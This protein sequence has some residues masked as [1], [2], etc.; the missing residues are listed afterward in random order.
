MQHTLLLVDDEKTLR[1]TLEYTLRREGYRVLTAADGPEA[2]RLAFGEAPDLIILDI[3]MP[4]MNGFDVC[5]AI[6]LQL[7]VPILMLS[8][9]EGEIDK[10]LAL[11]IGADDYLTKPFGL[12]ELLSR[13]RAPLRR[14]EMTS[15]KPLRA[16]EVGV[17]P[18]TTPSDKAATSV[19]ERP[20]APH[21]KLVAGSLTIDLMARTTYL[22]DRPITL[23]PR[24]FDLL[25]FL[26]SHPG[27]V[28]SRDVLLERI[29]GYDFVGSKRTVDSHISSLRRKLD[30]NP[31]GPE[32]I[33]TLFGVGYRFNQRLGPGV[34][35]R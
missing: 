10:V 29:W 30:S 24:E 1:D 34:G 13:V 11:E 4:G 6:R 33:Q 19:V 25:A 9:R 17:P 5:R 20:P 12:R 22:S 26:A 2:L 14:V 3:M 28:F 15:T 7:A 18:G 8:A 21:S 27:L 32:F 23:M 31:S 16:V 35:E